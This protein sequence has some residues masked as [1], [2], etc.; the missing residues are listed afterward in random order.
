VL[1]V[2]N[3]RYLAQHIRTAKYVSSRKSTIIHGSET[4]TRSSVRLKRS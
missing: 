3:G 1:K 2:E 4:R